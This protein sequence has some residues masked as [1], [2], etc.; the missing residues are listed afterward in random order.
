MYKF[1]QKKLP[2]NFD[3]FF[4]DSQSTRYNLRTNSQ[5]KYKL[6]KTHANMSNTPLHIEDQSYGITFS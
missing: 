2:S 1:A 4:I 3:K 6:P 5:N